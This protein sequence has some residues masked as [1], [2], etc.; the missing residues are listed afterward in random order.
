[1][2]CIVCVSCIVVYYIYVLCIDLRRVLPLHDSAEIFAVKLACWREAVPF[3][4]DWYRKERDNWVSVPGD[5]SQWW[6]WN[7]CMEAAKASV[8]QIQDYIARTE[9]GVAQPA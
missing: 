8:L 5:R 6:V 7:E 2:Y 3:I 4:K 1:M 9:Q